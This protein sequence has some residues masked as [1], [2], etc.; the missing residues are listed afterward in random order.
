MRTALVLPVTSQRPRARRRRS[1]REID[2]RPRPS[3]AAKSRGEAGPPCCRNRTSFCS[4]GS[5][6][7]SH[8]GTGSTVVMADVC[9]VA[10]GANL[11]RPLLISAL[12]TSLPIRRS[13]SCSVKWS[14]RFE[15]HCTRA[16]VRSRICNK[17][18]RP[19]TE[20]IFGLRRATKCKTTRQ[21]RDQ[22]PQRALPAR[23]TD[24]NSNG[25]GH[26]KAAI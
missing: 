9:A 7:D 21:R 10:T 16:G 12:V 24:M 17:T 4:T 5:Q 22:S 23:L 6:I 18:Q 26:A 14:R 20:P 13:A 2:V 11:N 25:S 3:T 15:A 19:P 1:F 8:T